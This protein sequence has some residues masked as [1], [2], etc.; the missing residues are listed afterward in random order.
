MNKLGETDIS[1]VSR[2]MV[3]V[4]M[5]SILWF[6]YVDFRQFLS[7]FLIIIILRE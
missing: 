7:L 3:C 6:R 1:V 4:F 2:S 5:G